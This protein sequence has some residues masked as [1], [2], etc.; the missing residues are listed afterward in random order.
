MKIVLAVCIYCVM[1][2]M[3]TARPGGLREDKEDRCRYDRSVAWDTS[4]CDVEGADQDVAMA[5][6]TSPLVS[7][8][9]ECNETKTLSVKCSK[10]DKRIA[11]QERIAE[12]KELRENGCKYDYWSAEW[13]S[14]AC[15]EEGADLSKAKGTVTME[16]K[17]QSNA[18]CPQF[19][20]KS[21]TCNR[22]EKW[23]F[24]KKQLLG[25]KNRIKSMR[26]EKLAARKQMKEAR[27]TAP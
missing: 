22:F 23:S 17:S 18:D 2:A 26:Q 12:R 1:V 24:W 21:V 11:R 15:E 27:E 9:E 25:L 3:V 14:T 20:V 7:G 19:R 6:R 16:L 5:T 10:V 4:A 13:N 8:P